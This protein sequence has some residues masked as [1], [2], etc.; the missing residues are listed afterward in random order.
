MITGCGQD[1]C[2]CGLHGPC[3]CIC[4]A[5]ESA[6]AQKARKT[7]TENVLRFVS[8]RWGQGQG[9][10]SF[11]AEV[12][13]LAKAKGLLGGT[14]IDEYLDTMARRYDM[15]ARALRLAARAARGED[16][17]TLATIQIDKD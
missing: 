10:G 12:T 3:M 6:N 17:R 2:A 13:K 9:P 5:C 14:T 4:Y 8:A 1:S 7:A 16:A 15:L 11:A